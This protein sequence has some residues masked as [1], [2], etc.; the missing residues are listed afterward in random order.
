VKYY[1]L[2]KIETGGVGVIKVKI[3]HPSIAT[4]HVACEIIEKDL[5]QH[6]LDLRAE[7]VRD[8]KS[9]D[10]LAQRLLETFPDVVR[11]RILPLSG[12]GCGI[13]VVK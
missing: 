5:K 9:I 8:H 2:H 12:K 6:I 13:E 1:S 7:G 10:W 3:E 4:F 11:V